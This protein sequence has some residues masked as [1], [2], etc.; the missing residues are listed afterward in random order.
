MGFF[1]QGAAEGAEFHGEKF[2]KPLK[3]LQVARLTEP[4]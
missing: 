1:L 3:R 4:F 2:E